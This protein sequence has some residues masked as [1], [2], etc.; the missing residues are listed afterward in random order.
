[1]VS[2]E[3]CKAHFNR[4]VAFLSTANG[5]SYVQ[6]TPI[7]LSFYIC[8]DTYCTC[9]LYISDSY[10]MPFEPSPSRSAF[11]SD[12]LSK[13]PEHSAL[14]CM[15]AHERFAQ[16]FPFEFIITRGH[17]VQYLASRAA[18]VLMWAAKT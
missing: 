14:I 3:I 17:S 2:E 9:V 5:V 1:M 10:A 6:A 11:R 16:T 13:E 18:S 7:S 12:G 8:T 15:N 4:Y